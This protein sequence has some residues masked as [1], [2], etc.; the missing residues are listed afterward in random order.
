MQ[1]TSNI[2]SLSEQGIQVSRNAHVEVENQAM[3]SVVW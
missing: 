3:G 1:E 2:R